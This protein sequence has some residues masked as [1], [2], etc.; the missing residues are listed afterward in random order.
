MTIRRRDFLKL[1]GAALGWMN[2]SQLI[3]SLL[4]IVVAE[5]VQR[6]A[7]PY[8]VFGPATLVGVLG[9][10]AG[11]GVE[12]VIAAVLVGFSLAV[13]FVVTLALPAILSRPGD[14]HRMSA[15]MFTISYSCAVLVP[16]ICGALCTG[17][18]SA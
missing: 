11:S 15:G 17:T 5:H 4:L 13:T 9:I 1:T 7:W 6:R 14:V 18:S 16:P 3:A 10:V 12:I 8:F 2:S